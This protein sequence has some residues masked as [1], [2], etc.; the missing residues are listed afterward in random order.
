MSPS[1]FLLI[2]FPL[3]SSAQFSSPDAPSSKTSYSGKNGLTWGYGGYTAH[4]Q[5]LFHVSCSGTPLVPEFSPFN[6]MSGSCNPYNGD[7]PCVLSLPLLCIEQC[8]FNRPCYSVP[9]GPGAMPG[10]F[11][12]GWTEGLLRLTEPVKGTLLTSRAAANTICAKAFG[13]GFR[14]AAHNDGRYVVGMDDSHY[15]Y[16]TWPLGS[17]PTGGWGYYGYGVKGPRWTRF[18]VAID[19]TTGNC[20][21]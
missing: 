10:E 9:C 8:R 4:E 14:M 20:W 1:F 16:S 13:P 18:W 21:N 12:C 11:Y 7:T 2:L 15:C 5:E 6:G 17:A 3:F 19:D